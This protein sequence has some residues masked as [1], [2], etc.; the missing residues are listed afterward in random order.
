VVLTEETLDPRGLGEL[1]EVF[2]KQLPWSDLPVLVFSSREKKADALTPAMLR[3]GSLVNLVLLDRPTRKISLVSAALSAL[4]AR[5]RQ[6]EVRD[7]LLQLETAVRDRDRFLAVLG[8]E[9]R[10]PLSAILSSVQLIERLGA[11]A[12]AREQAVILRQTR[13]LSRLVDD[14]LDVSRVTSGKIALESAAVDLRRLLERCVQAQT[15]NAADRRIEISID[16]EQGLTAQGDP[17]RLE[18]V[19]NNLLTNAVK[20]T[21]AGGRVRVTLARRGGDAEVRVQ[22]TGVGIAPEVLPHVFDMF[23]QADDTLDRSQ[24]G[25]GI[26]LTLVRSLVELHGGSVAAESPGR[27][28]GSTFIVRLPAVRTRARPAAARSESPASPAPREILLVEDNADV[29]EGLKLLLEEAGHSVDV[30]GDGIEA[31]ERIAERRPSLALLDIGLPRLDG[32]SL[33]RR[34]R[35]ALGG[36]VYLVALTGY[37]LPEDRHRAMEAGFDAH[38]AKPITLDSL[39]A[40][41]AR[42]EPTR[43]GPIRA[44]RPAGVPSVGEAVGAE[45]RRASG[46]SAPRPRT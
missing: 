8:H 2:S 15:L 43:A 23:T 30:A 7:L 22:D 45:P 42:A 24:G 34:M 26:G 17:V 14:L 31:L 35:E 10:N 9:L 1:A 39:L 38:L 5:A 41:L 37:G 6:Y 21:P 40:L 18:Q 11:K 19:F 12:V 3:L 44:D 4:R 25:L 13:L 36:S 46:R 16:L 20:Y 33:A 28:E 27:G 32:Y 29:R